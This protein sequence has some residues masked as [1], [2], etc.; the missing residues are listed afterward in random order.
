MPSISIGNKKRIRLLSGFSYSQLQ[1]LKSTQSTYYNGQL[2][3]VFKTTVT[4]GTNN[5]SFDYL[6]GI[7]YAVKSIHNKEINLLLLANHGLTP[8]VKENG[9]EISISVIS[10]IIS[11]KLDRKPNLKS[12]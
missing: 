6:F 9:Q 8:V 4:W 3:Q 7:E 11:L 2:L 5:N 10:F 12:P 1:K